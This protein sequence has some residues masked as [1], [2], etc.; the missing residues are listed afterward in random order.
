[1]NNIGGKKRPEWNHVIIVDQKRRTFRCKCRV[2]PILCNSEMCDKFGLKIKEIPGLIQITDHFSY[3]ISS[4]N[5]LLLL[6][7]KSGTEL[8]GGAVPFKFDRCML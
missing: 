6:Q 7:G 4:L 2:V 3:F 8:R 5:F 1:M